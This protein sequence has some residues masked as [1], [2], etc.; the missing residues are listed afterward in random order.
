MP[1]LPAQPEYAGC[2]FAYPTRVP[3]GWVFQF[4]PGPNVVLAIHSSCW[5]SAQRGLY[6]IVAFSEMSMT[7]LLARKLVSNCQYDRAIP[8]SESPVQPVSPEQRPIFAYVSTSLPPYQC[9]LFGLLLNT[10]A[11]S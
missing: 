10:F 6:R 4:R 7:R 11:Q 5:A 2:A 8:I 1:L 9:V 3:A